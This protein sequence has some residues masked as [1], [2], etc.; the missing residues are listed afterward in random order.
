[1]S[2]NSADFAGMA[3]PQTANARRRFRSPPGPWQS[4]GGWTHRITR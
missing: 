1:M 2:R 3:E 4:V